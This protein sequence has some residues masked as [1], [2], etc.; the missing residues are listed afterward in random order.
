M[1]SSLGRGTGIPKVRRALSNNHSPKADFNTDEART[2]FDTTI[3]IHPEFLKDLEAPVGVHEGV[4]EGI[5]DISDM[6]R[7]LLTLVAKEPQSMPVILEELG[8]KSRNRNVRTAINKL[9]QDGLLALTITDKP[10]SKKQQYQI[11]AL[12]R[13]EFERLQVK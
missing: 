5:H 10:K 12:G 6:G 11:T 7:K 9:I 13:Q 2:Y 1:A 8:Y 4:H 3:Q